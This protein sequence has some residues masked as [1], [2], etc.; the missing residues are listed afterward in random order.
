MTVLFHNIPS[1][2][3]KHG[4]EMAQAPIITTNAWLD[5]VFAAGQVAKGN[6]VRRSIRDV[7]KYSS[8]AELKAAV[9]Q[10]GFHLAKIGSQYV[11]LC[12]PPGALE[13]IC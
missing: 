10:N 6:V 5:Q 3:H 4:V 7:E 13:I 11:I 9:R 2:I 1:I 8:E 12:N